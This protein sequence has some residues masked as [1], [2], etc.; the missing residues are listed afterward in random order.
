MKKV[1]DLDFYTYE[2]I[3]LSFFLEQLKK[4]K[5]KLEK[6]GYDQFYLGIS[7]DYYGEEYYVLEGEK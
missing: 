7:K 2:Q 6:R 4:A 1:I 5:K 3:E